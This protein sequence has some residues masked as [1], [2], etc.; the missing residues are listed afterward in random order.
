M[1]LNNKFAQ[2]IQICIFVFSINNAFASADA[3]Q[4]LADCLKIFNA[5]S[6]NFTQII[7]TPKG[8]IIQKSK[9]NM[10][11]RRPGLLRWETTTPNQQLIIADGRD[12]WIYDKDLSQVMRQKQTTSS[13][14]PALLLSD[15]VEKFISKFTIRF[16]QNIHSMQTPAFRL[17]PKYASESA[18]FE[19]IEL[20]FAQKTLR[21]M[22][23]HDHLGQ[24]TEISFSQVDIPVSMSKNL[25]TFVSPKNVDILPVNTN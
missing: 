1:R 15:S 5:V 22:I 24:V 3:S 11:L 16:I 12:I 9:G 2:F 17:T 7:Y 25:F 20:I 13:H 4:T 19:F 6:A 14:T 23:L 18:L 21:K 8:N 10:A